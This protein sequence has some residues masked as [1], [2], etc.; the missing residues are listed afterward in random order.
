M[1]ANYDNVIVG[2]G[3]AGCLLVYGRSD[4]HRCVA[5]S[6]WTADRAAD[7]VSSAVQDDKHGI[8]TMA[9]KLRACG[10]ILAVIFLFTPVSLACAAD[11]TI[12]LGLGAGFTLQLARHFNTILVAD[13]NIVDVLTQSDRSVVLR[14]RNPGA[15]NIIFLDEASI[16]IINVRILVHPQNRV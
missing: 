16:A 2:A 6:R 4:R 15:T 13:P 3:S 8:L 11:Q 5:R 1:K 10:V 14:P 9:A 7:R 12:I